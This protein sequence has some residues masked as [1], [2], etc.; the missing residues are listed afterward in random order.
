MGIS[1]SSVLSINV[2]LIFYTRELNEALLSAT[3][4]HALSISCAAAAKRSIVLST[5]ICITV[6]AQVWS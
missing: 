5:K 2:L 4:F 1:R 6:I 3:S